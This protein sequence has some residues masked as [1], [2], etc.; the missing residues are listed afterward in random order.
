MGRIRK[1][2]KIDGNNYWT[3]FDSGSRNNY[4]VNDITKNMLAYKLSKPQKSSLGGRIYEITMQCILDCIIEGK[5][6]TG[7]SRVVEEIGKDDDKKRIEILI[8]ALTMQEWGIKL[9]MEKEEL[10]MTNYPEEFVE[11]VT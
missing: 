6:V 10:D 4:I 11:F 9:D 2:I 3:L 8:G 7:H 5:S 1:N